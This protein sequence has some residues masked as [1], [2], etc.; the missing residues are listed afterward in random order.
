L[1]TPA[2]DLYWLPLG[3]GGHSVKYNGR[4]FEAIVAR[5][6][7]RPALDI[8]HS[9]LAV[10]VAVETYVIE[11]AP[12]RDNRGAERGVVAE[13]AVGS[14]WAGYLRLFRYEIRRWHDGRI[15]DVAEAVESPR[16]LTSDPDMAQRVL[17]LVPQVP[18]PVWGR[19]GLK[20]GEMWN[21][22]SVTAWVIARSGL[23]IRSIRPPAGGRAPGWDAGQIVAGRQTG[24]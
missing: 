12:I 24:S 22:N 7:G 16:R 6:E 10:R 8:Y 2:V 20:A 13:G 3:A 17:D 21:S 15:P 14:R 19:D 23:P 9:A 1:T 5:R 11:M 18:T 4:V